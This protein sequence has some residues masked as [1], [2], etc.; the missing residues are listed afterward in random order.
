M[1]ST[2]LTSGPEDTAY[3]VQTENNRPGDMQSVKEASK[4]QKLQTSKEMLVNKTCYIVMNYSLS[5]SNDL[6]NKCAKFYTSM[7]ILQN[8]KNNSF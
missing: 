3:D 1:K 2:N 6:H 5:M 4:I 8:C 7:L